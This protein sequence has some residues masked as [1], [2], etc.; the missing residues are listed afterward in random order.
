MSWALEIYFPEKPSPDAIQEA[1]PSKSLEIEWGDS[2]PQGGFFRVFRKKRGK[3]EDFFHVKGPIRRA[4]GDVPSAFFPSLFFRRWK[5]SL[6]VPDP[7]G[8][9]RRRAAWKWAK[10][11]AKKGEGVI[12]HE[13]SQILGRGRKVVEV[14]EVPGADQNVPFVLFQWHFLENEAGEGKARRF[15]ETFRKYMCRYT[16]FFY[17]KTPLSKK[18]WLLEV[19]E[20]FEGAW[21]RGLKAGE[22]ARVSF[23]AEKPFYHPEVV[24][25]DVKE[26]AFPGTVSP[27]TRKVRV[28]LKCYWKDW[29]IKPGW[30]EYVAE[31]FPRVAGELE[32]FYAIAYVENGFC[33]DVFR[34]D[35]YNWTEG[36]LYFHSETEDYPIADNLDWL[37]LPPCPGWLV[38]FGTPYVERVRGGLDELRDFLGE[39]PGAEFEELENGL[40]IRMSGKPADFDHLKDVPYR[41]PEDLV[42]K[43]PPSNFHGDYL[44][45]LREEAEEKK[46]K[47]KKGAG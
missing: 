1:L 8:M 20:D 45:K 23:E 44:K 47:R 36:H 46:K 40:F 13:G 7:P 25:G 19:A 33:L 18:E 35:D 16:P 42:D 21:K 29:H 14:P 4:F 34:I 24:F 12:L 6:H 17:Q 10:R 11:L 15:L 26:G 32:C 27:G 3:A 2:G 28:G 37:G 30:R 43:T 22:P 39:R 31:S 41:L 5:F 38:W 9:R